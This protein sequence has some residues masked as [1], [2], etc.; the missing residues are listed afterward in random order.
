MHQVLIIGCGNI[1]GGFDADR[2]AGAPPLTHA[3]AFAQHP[4]FAV[5]AC[6]DP[7]EV[8][9]TAF[10]AHWSVGE[11]ASHVAALNAERGRFHVVSICSPTRFH[12]EHIDAALAL[13]PRLIFCEKP[14]AKTSREMRALAD[15]CAAQGVLLAVNYTRRW[16]PDVV[17][18]ASDLRSGAWGAVRSVHGVYSK[19]VVHNGGHM[20]DLLHL[21]LGEM[22]L[23][24][25]GGPSFD[26]WNGDPSVPALLVT[27]QGVPV[28]LAIGHA[29]DYALFELVLVTE[30]GTVAMLDG[31]LRWSVR[32]AGESATFVGY[33]DLGAIEIRDGEYDQA[34]RCAVDNIAGALD[35]GAPLASNAG[36]AH[37]AQL[38]C[39]TI[40]DAAL[41]VTD[42]RRTE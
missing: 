17:R 3:G 2:A 26:F 25:A 13:G 34:M 27:R 9:R 37:A 38:L 33:R 41:A 18:L 32:R 1:A 42:R 12:A 19:G 7:D 21:L 29:G 15:R 11:G 8:Q 20:I 14:V 22:D 10:Q 23:I 5:T 35:R 30:R 16:A 4:D 31:G 36:N 39:E 24:A 40:R 6:V 28:T